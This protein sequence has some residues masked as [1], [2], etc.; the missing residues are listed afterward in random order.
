MESVGVNEFNFCYKDIM[1]GVCHK[2]VTPL[3]QRE[4][5][6]KAFVIKGCSCLLQR[7]GVWKSFVTLECDICYMKRIME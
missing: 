5:E 7:V 1:E 4:W 3:L 6:W 2:L